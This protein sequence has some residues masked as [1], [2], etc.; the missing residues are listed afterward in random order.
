MHRSL[1]GN[2]MSLAVAATTIIAAAS[3]TAT[4]GSF[5]SYVRFGRRAQAQAAAQAAREEAI[6]L[7]QTRA[8]VIAELQA[9]LRALE[10]AYRVQCLCTAA[11]AGL[12]REAR[13]ELEADPPDVRAAL[14][15][16]R[17]A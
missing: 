11:L 4:V 9:K 8:A 2:E 10:D 1:A 15:R 12:V 17:G 6:A 7:A 13:A 3:A 14:T 16:L 5:V